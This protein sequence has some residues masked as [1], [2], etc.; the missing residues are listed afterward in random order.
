MN[1]RESGSSELDQQAWLGSSR[2]RD[3]RGDVGSPRQPTEA[4]SNGTT[5]QDSRERQPRGG[6]AERERGRSESA[7]A[8]AGG[9]CVAQ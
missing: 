1:L 9:G 5:R 8:A 2:I 7:A 4:G 6:A 3:W